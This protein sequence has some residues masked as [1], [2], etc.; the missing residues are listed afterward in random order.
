[1]ITVNCKKQDLHFHFL[2]NNFCRNLIWYC[3]VYTSYFQ[4]IYRSALINLKFVEKIKF[5]IDK[6]N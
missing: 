2:E 5:T 3:D 4:V 1:M 6:L